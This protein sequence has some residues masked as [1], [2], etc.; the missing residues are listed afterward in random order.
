MPSPWR[1][2]WRAPARGVTR[3][4]NGIGKRRSRGN[5]AASPRGRKDFLR[6]QYGIRIEGIAQPPHH[7]QIVIGEQQRHHLVFLHAYA[8]LAGERSAYRDAKRQ[9]VARR[10]QRPLMLLW[11]P[12]I[13]KYQ[14]M[15]IAI[16]GMKNVAD[17]ERMLL[18][19]LFDLAQ[20]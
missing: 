4:D 17:S 8:V 9:D 12:R 10:R 11:N 19:D 15:Q 1:S 16:A 2:C 5:L 3:A 14:G 6:I 13:K 7:F 18:G 20:R